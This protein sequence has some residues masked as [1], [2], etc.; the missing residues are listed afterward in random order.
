MIRLLRA[1]G[2]GAIAGVEVKKARREAALV[3]GADIVIDP[4]REDLNVVLDKMFGQGVRPTV[5]FECAGV[6]ASFSGA[7]D[8][9]ALG[10][11]VVMVAMHEQPSTLIPSRIVERGLKIL[12]SCGYNIGPDS[13]AVISLLRRKRIDL[14]NLV[15]H[16]F[17]LEKAP[18][19]FQTSLLDEAAVKILVT[20]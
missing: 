10:G 11:T 6:P 3:S 13:R 2:C 16:R 14:A 15:S 9:V 18:Q 12:G 19:A 8:L 1:R 4:T 7:L 17:P 20:Q 5:V